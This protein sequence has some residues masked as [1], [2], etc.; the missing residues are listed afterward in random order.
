MFKEIVSQISFSPAMVEQLSVYARTIKQ[1]RRISGW[2]LIIVG[3]LLVLQIVATIVPPPTDPTQGP[4]G[5]SS[6]GFISTLYNE[7][8]TPTSTS[9]FSYVDDIADALPSLSNA[10]I[11]GFSTLLLIVNFFTYLS[12][13][14]RSKEIRIIRTQLNTGAL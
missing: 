11:I 12:L 4:T 13:G 7:T 1:R 5:Q 8:D 6:D 2:S 14:L 3:A 9:I 10:T